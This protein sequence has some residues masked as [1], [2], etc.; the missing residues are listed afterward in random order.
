MPSLSDC[1]LCEHP[2]DGSSLTD[3]VTGRSF[4]P[5]CLAERAPQDAVLAL[6]GALAL[7]LAPP[8]IVWAG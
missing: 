5:A 3:A 8:V 2:L 6:L 1:P 4:H 7:A